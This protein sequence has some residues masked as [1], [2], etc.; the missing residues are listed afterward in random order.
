MTVGEAQQRLKVSDSTVRNWIDDGLLR[1]WWT[2]GGHRRIDPASLEE[3][4]HALRI[5]PGPEREQALDE[6]RHRNRTRGR[7]A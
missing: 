5:P 3:L 1:A 2:A 7:G 4:I 6:L